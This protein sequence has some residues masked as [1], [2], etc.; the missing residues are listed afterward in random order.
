MRHSGVVTSSTPSPDL[1]FLP[2]DVQQAARRTTSGREVLWPRDSAASAIE[3]LAAAG[4]IVLGLDLRRY[5]TDQSFLEAPWSIFDPSSRP[6]EPLVAAARQVALD[7]LM[8]A[9]DGEWNQYDWV[10]VTWKLPD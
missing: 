5:D 6:L 2:V 10:L 4:R 8:R 1:T 9:D 7:A 3:A